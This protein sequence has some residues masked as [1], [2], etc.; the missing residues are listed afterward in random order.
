MCVSHVLH[1][2][3]S[4]LSDAPHR[5]GRLFYSSIGVLVPTAVPSLRV[6]HTM[7]GWVVSYVMLRVTQ[8]KMRTERTPKHGI[9]G[10]EHGRNK[11][12][13][14]S[15][16]AVYRGSNLHMIPMEVL[17]VWSLGPMPST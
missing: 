8:P 5:E 16:P 9:S 14:V 10:A 4:I 1:R 2:L 13:H 17:A 7:G 11:H 3:D 15:V 6:E 12:E